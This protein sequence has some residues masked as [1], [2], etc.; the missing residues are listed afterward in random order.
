M[1]EVAYSYI[2]ATANLIGNSRFGDK[3]ILK[4]GSALISKIIEQ[5]R[6]N[7][8]IHCDKR[9]VW[10]DFYKNI[11]EILNNNNLGYVYT[12]IDRRSARRGLVDS[13]SLKFKL[14][15]ERKG[16][17]TFFR[18]DMNIKSNSIITCEYSPMLQMTTYDVL[19]MLA[20]KIAVVASPKVYRRIK[21]LY[22]IYVIANLYDLEYKDVW[23]HLMKKR[24][25]AVLEHMLTPENYG[26]LKHA[27]DLYSGIM[28]K[29]P[30]VDVVGTNISFL[31]PI[32]F[33][34][35]DVPNM[36]WRKRVG[37]WVSCSMDI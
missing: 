23:E 36:V 33:M 4:G 14:V 25:T 12:I 3:L 28:N 21:D 34:G 29:P 22:D 5:R 7:L 19:T 9:E 30:F 11:E 31:Y 32:I 35:Q 17:E 27:Y 6:I 18:I 13:D 20:D 24:G 2:I 16:T 26:E 37:A 8:D 15:D 1:L 10:I